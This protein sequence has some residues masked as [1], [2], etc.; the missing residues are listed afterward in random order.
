MMP[1]LTF[2][3]IRLKGDHGCEYTLSPAKHYRNIR[4]LTMPY[5]CIYLNIFVVI[6][7]LCIYIIY[8]IF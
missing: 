7:V 3:Q 2:S 5:I 6:Y 1:A 4:H 8:F